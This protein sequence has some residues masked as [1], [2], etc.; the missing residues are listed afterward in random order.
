MNKR[1]FML[2]FGTGI[3]VGAALLQLF[4]IGQGAGLTTPLNDE[5][6]TYTQ[7]ELDQRIVEERAKFEA[8]LTKGQTEGAAGTTKTAQPT[9]NANTATQPSTGQNAAKQPATGQA[10]TTKQPAAGQTAT[11]KQ[12]TA[13]T[14]AG[15]TGTVQTSEEVIGIGANGRLILRILPGKAL[16]DVA[17]LLYDN[18]VIA[19]KKTFIAQM[20]GK[21]IRAGYFGF[22][23]KLTLKQVLNVLTS[24]PIPQKQALEEIA[25]RKANTA[26]AQTSS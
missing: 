26:A 2:G 4:L 6:A 24:K 8:E 1:T 9:G 16:Q 18:K 25:A 10:T 23:G 19:D 20:R 12:P 13:G 22:A 7:E 17:N 14:A 11:T 5:G 21:T 3:I 15:T